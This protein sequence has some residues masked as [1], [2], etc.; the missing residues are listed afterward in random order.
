[1]E[2]RGE[3]DWEREAS[4]TGRE[5]RAILGERGEREWE[6][7]ASETRRRGE[8]GGKEWEKDE[9]YMCIGY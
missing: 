8:R 3:R 5:R 1:M 2:E 7:E 6:R 9:L 4:E